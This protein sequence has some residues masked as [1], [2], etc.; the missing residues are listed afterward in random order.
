[1]SIESTE[2]ATDLTKQVEYAEGLSRKTREDDL[3]RY[4]QQ[5]FDFIPV[6]LVVGIIED[7]K[8]NYNTLESK[9]LSKDMDLVGSMIKFL[10][11]IPGEKAKSLLEELN[12][13]V[14][15]NLSESDHSQ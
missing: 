6:D 7:L 15:T 4:L 12:I 11:K 9:L 2:S 5:G 8:S 13:F 3:E 1:M 10:E 14:S